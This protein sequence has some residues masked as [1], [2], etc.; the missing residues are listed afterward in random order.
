MKEEIIQKA[1]PLFLKH[2]IRK[3]S[4]N[5]LV[6]LLGISTKTLYKYFKNKEDLLEKVLLHYHDQQ[7]EMLKTLPTGQDAASLFFSVWQHAVEIECKTN[8]LFYEDLHYYYPELEKK[9]NKRISTKF[10]RFFLSILESGIEEGNFR[11]DVNPVAALRTIFVL[12]ST[13]VRT[14]D[15]Q[16][17]RLSETDLLLTT[18]GTY[19]RGLCTEN[20]LRNLDD[21]ITGLRILPKTDI[22][23]NHHS[24]H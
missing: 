13:A 22:I 19:I 11:K 21:N 12:H 20:G 23:N 4:N 6:D 17:L 5:N 16:D 24:V 10:E 14:K 18:T 15:L 9:V 2:G 1:L 3:M 7:Y 8:K